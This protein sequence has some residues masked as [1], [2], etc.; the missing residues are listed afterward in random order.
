MTGGFVPAAELR[1]GDKLQWH[2]RDSF[3]DGEIDLVEVAEAALVGWLQSDGSVGGR[4]KRSLTI[5]AITVN[6]DE[7]TWVSEALDRV[8]P[9]VHRHEQVQVALDEGL[10]SRRIRLSARCS[11][12]SSTG[13]GSGLAAPTW[14]SRSDSSP[15]P[16]PSWRRTSG[17]SSRRRATCGCTRHPASLPSTWS[18][19]SSSV[20]CSSCS[21]ASVSSPG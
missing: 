14:R 1:A 10:E 20:A 16:S 4:R 15:R 18:R 5:E 8:F 19:R 12:R 11:S 17:A 9:M 2:R 6:E 7:H 13:G 21:P 3:G